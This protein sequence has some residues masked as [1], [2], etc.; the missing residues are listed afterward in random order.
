[1]NADKASFFLKN[2]IGKHDVEFTY[3]SKIIKINVNKTAQNDLTVLKSRVDHF[4]EISELCI[5]GPD[6]EEN[7][8]EIATSIKNLLSLAFGRR[9]TFDRH[10]YWYSGNKRQYIKI[11]SKNSNYGNQIIPDYMISN[12]LNLVL[13]NWVKLSIQEKDS[14]FVIFD[15]LNQTSEDFLEDRVLRTVQAWE[16]YGYYFFEEVKL[17]ERFSSLRKQL[18]QTYKSWKAEVNFID[19]GVLIQRILNSIDQEKL[20]AKYDKIIKESRLDPNKISLD[21]RSLKGLRD[22]VAH[23]GKI[24]LNSYSAHA[25]LQSGV[26][27]LQLILLKRLGYNDLIFAI[28][29]NSRKAKKFDDYFE[30]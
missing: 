1:M 16:C 15:Y 12:Y 4:P 24:D 6:T 20:M 5:L 26:F 7:L 28:E 17:P 8:S 21:F 9:I 13:P 22:K 25:L 23:T 11:M 18:K 19:N 27:G 3:G 10:E 14:L 30:K 29:N 2:F